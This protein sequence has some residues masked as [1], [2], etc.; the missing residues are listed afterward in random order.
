MPLDDSQFAIPCLIM[1]G[2]SSRGGFFL[3]ADLPRD[4]VQR[5]AVLLA[6]YGSPDERQIDGI[7][8][9]DP[10]TSK[11]AIVGPSAVEGA[12]VDYTFCQIGIGEPRVS[13]G[14]NCG[15]MLAAVGPFALLRGLVAARSPETRVRIYTTN[16]R[17]IVTARVP[18]EHGLPQWDG[19]SKTPGVPGTGAPI[20]LDF[21]DCTG[22]VSGKLLPTGVGTDVIKV[23]GL[24]VRVSLVDAATPFVFV[25]AADIGASG[26]ELPDAMSKDERL[27]PRLESIRGWAAT[28]LGLV[29]TPELARKLSPNVP[30]VMM[31]SPARN[32]RTISGETMALGDMDVCVRQLT[33]QRP[34]KALAVTGA[35][36]VAVAALVPGTVVADCAGGLK[37]VLRVGHPSG[38]LRVT[39]KVHQSSGGSGLRV[40]SAVIERTARLIMSGWV[41]ARR[42]TVSTLIAE[43]SQER[44]WELA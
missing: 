25:A 12:D 37:D 21:G 3:E 35:I 20:Y 18:T 17:Q 19:P 39:S 2:G 8:G 36:C 44:Q 4:P 22:S 41:H 42:T 1:R 24:K 34:H 5:N 28:E 33:M 16:T 15:N 10:L 30:R 43:G 7:G 31:V 9:A 29:R 32:Y 13:T 11:A 40:Q 38:V 14:G 27:V 26:I 6:C 23:D